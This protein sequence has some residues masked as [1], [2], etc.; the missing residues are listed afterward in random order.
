MPTFAEIAD[1]VGA[2]PLKSLH[3]TEESKPQKAEVK[4]PPETKSRSGDRFVVIVRQ[5]GRNRGLLSQKVFPRD[6]A[7][8]RASEHNRTQSS[9]EPQAHIHKVSV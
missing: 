9:S 3:N 4:P 5:N 7:L 1:Q 6:E 8:K 2:D